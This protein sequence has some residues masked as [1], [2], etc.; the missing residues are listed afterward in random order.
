MACGSNNDEICATRETSNDTIACQRMQ[1]SGTIH[2]AD[3]GY[4]MLHGGSSSGYLLR[5]FLEVLLLHEC[6][7]EIPNSIVKGL[8]AHFGIAIGFLNFYIL[9]TEAER[10]TV[11]VSE[12]AIRYDVEGCGIFIVSQIKS[13]RHH[14]I[15]RGLRESAAVV[16]NKGALYHIS[17]AVGWFAIAVFVRCLYAWAL[18]V[19]MTLN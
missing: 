4:Y 8:V 15:L 19:Q 16:G 14:A 6:S 9:Q 7:K 11:A 18:A 3:A 17:K 10:H 5:R 1:S 2:S 13:V 12:Q